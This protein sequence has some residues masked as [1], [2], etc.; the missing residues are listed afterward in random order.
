MEQML[1]ML[2]DDGILEKDG[3]GRWILIREVGAI[4]ILE[5]QALLSARLDRLGP[6]DRVVVERA[7]VDGQVFFRGAVEDL[8]PAEVRRHTGESLRT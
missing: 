8:S 4:T 3:R 7:S 2:L 6:I 5:I 1:S